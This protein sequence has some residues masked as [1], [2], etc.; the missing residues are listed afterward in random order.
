MSDTNSSRPLFPF[1]GVALF[2]CCALTGCMSPPEREPPIV[3]KTDNTPPPAIMVEHDGTVRVLEAPGPGSTQAPRAPHGH[4]DH[5]HGTHAPHRHPSGGSGTSNAP[6]Y[7]PPA[8]E[9]RPTRSA[10]D[11]VESYPSRD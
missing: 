6:V 10:R 3:Y 11:Y 5:D 7:V 9:S 1:V 4:Y 2:A 8:R